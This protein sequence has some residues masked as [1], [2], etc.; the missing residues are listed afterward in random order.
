[1]SDQDPVLHHAAHDVHRSPSRA[2]DRLS[3]IHAN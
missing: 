2:E 1:M 3:I